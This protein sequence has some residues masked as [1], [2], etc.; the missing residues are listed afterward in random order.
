VIAGY[1]A[2]A[3]TPARTPREASEA[4]LDRHVEIALRM[5]LAVGIAALLLPLLAQ[6]S[7]RIGISVMGNEMGGMTAGLDGGPGLSAL[8]GFVL[9]AL[10]SYAGSRM[11]SRRARRSGRAQQPP[12]NT[13]RR[14]ATT[15]V[16]SGSAS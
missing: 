8:T 2:S 3:R 5:G 14:A 10:A 1:V 7:L 11:H 16:P 13:K 9:A 12:G 15:R 6:A 4:L